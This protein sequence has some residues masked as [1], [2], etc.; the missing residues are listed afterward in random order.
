MV[1]KALA[2]LGVVAT[3]GVL[4]FLA[5]VLNQLDSQETPS[6]APTEPSNDQPTSLPDE[7]APPLGEHSHESD[8][9]DD[10]GEYDF[11][12]VTCDTKLGAD[13]AAQIK[14]RVFDYELYWI[15]PDSEE[16]Q[17]G[18][19]TYGTEAYVKNQ[20]VFVDPTLSLEQGPVSIAESSIYSCRVTDRGNAQ[21]SII[22][23]I[24][25]H[26]SSEDDAPVVETTTGIIHRSVWSLE[27]GEWRIAYEDWG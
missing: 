23:D 16:K 6:T 4:V 9:H 3:I 12:D 1:R 2:V 24:Q 15:M 8:D 25:L 27:D 11:E 13:V 20:S 18:I 10:E 7:G 26:E 14:A 21:I 22:P 17:A 19:E 5:V